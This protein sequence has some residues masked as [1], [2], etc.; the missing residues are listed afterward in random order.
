MKPDSR[1]MTKAPVDPLVIPTASH[2]STNETVFSIIT[3][4]VGPDAHIVDF[5]AGLGYMSN[6]VAHWIETGG[7]DPKKQFTACDLDPAQFR[8]GKVRCVGIPPD[9]TFPS[10]IQSADLIYSV[11]VLE[12]LPRP[13]DFFANAYAALKPGGYLLVTTPNLLHMTARMGLLFQGYQT[14]FAPPS[15][16]PE[17]AGRICG[18]IMPLGYGQIHAGLRKAGFT[19]L[20]LHIDRAKRGAQILYWLYW[21]WLMLGSRVAL[22]RLQRVDPP[23]YEETGA[24]MEALNGR[25]LS[26]ARSCIVMARKPV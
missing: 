4:A 3:S 5:G 7:G 22:R 25:V 1:R 14:M 10:N 8:C 16:K 15:A 18:H 26:T 17:N 9:S 2:P 12:H 11:E 21:P 23:L 24:I 6:R 19:D 13:Y 20:T